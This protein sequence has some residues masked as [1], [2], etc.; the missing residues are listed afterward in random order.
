M[1]QSSAHQ[2]FPVKVRAKTKMWGALKFKGEG[3]QLLQKACPTLWH[4]ITHHTKAESTIPATGKLL[5]R[6][7]RTGHI[8]IT[9]KALESKEII[10]L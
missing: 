5:G 3:Y 2:T 6:I 7:H 4:F 8:M 9:L 1:I 10:S